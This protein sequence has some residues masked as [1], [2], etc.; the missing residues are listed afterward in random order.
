[1]ELAR[2]NLPQLLKAR[3]APDL[4]PPSD[5]RHGPGL[6]QTAPGDAPAL[7]NVLRKVEEDDVT[8]K[9]DRA[10]LDELR[11]TVRAAALMVGVSL[12][13]M[14]M[15]FYRV[16]EG[17]DLNM[18][19]VHVTLSVPVIVAVWALVVWRIWRRS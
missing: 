2:A 5:G 15:V 4:D 7:D 13:A 6:P 11:R 8:I 14:S 17:P 19:A 18:E 10:Y 9:L 3:Y 12:I 1:M 16:W